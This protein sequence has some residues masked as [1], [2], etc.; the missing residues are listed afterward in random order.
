MKK[1][2][3]FICLAA[4]L[5]LFSCGRPA[6]KASRHRDGGY[7]TDAWVKTTPVKNQGQSALCWVYAMLATI[8]SEHLMMGD[9]VN[10]SADFPARMLLQD[11]AREYFF[12]RRDEPISLRGMCATALR[13]VEQYGAEP[14]DSYYT[15]EP[16]NY[17][18]L[19]RK[20]EQVARAS[21]SLRQMNARL[22]DLLDNEIGF[23]PRYVFM[24]GMEYTPLQFGRSV[25]MP[26][27][28]LSLTSFDHHPFGRRCV[29]ETP[30]NVLRDSFYNVPI[31]RL[32]HHAV[33]ALRNGHPV[34]W[35]GDISEP[36][37]DFAAG[38]AVLQDERA[39]IDQRQ[40]QQHF[41]TLQ[42]TDDHAMMLCGLAH[43][44]HGN[45]YFIAKNSWGKTNSTGGYIYLSYNYVKLKTVA[46]YMSRKAYRQGDGNRQTGEER[47]RSRK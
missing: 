7:T 36:G 5:L 4:L 33:A 40:R 3:V 14:F 27:E 16:V 29:L 10:L 18:V 9:S 43:D 19:A 47:T 45:R 12:S 6:G 22:Q 23:M 46:M 37:F 25:C 35:E 42:T 31:D 20:V 30:D 32:M 17:G 21:V 8:E 26:D 24:L 34:C 1:K 38:R 41:E 44:R 2:A 15:R 28:Y 13:L 39:T 11:K